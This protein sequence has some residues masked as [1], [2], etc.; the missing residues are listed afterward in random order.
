MNPTDTSSGADQQVRPALARLLSVSFDDFADKHWGTAP[1]LSRADDL[2][3][4]FADLFSNDAVDELISRRGLRTPFLRVAKDGSTLADAEFTRAGGVGAGVT[5]QLSD[6]RLLDLFAG[7]STLVLQALHRTWPPIID[8]TGQLST[9]LGHPVQVNSYTTPAQ[10]T[11]FSSH[12]DVHDVFVLQIAGAK[13]WQIREP[14]LTTPL[15][16]QPWDQRRAQVEAASTGIPLLEVTLEPGD[17][18]YLPRGYLHAATAL[19]EISTH[20]TIGVHTWTRTH[21]LHTLSRY[22]VTRLA[23]DADLRA[24]FPPGLDWSGVPVAEADLELVR[25]RLVAAL[26]QVRLSDLADAL[27]TAHLGSQRAEPV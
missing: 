1:L 25:D 15:R 5:D 4:G 6:D 23:D 12:Y 9:D 3:S 2:P 21:L 8:F 19:G 22:A 16:S 18:L 26:R 20:L 14:I 17:C 7:G 13:R 24:A 11:G 27:H 10:N